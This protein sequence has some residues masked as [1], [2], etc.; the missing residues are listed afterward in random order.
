MLLDLEEGKD[1]FSTIWAPFDVA[2]IEANFPAEPEEQL[3]P[4]LGEKMA[5]HQFGYRVIHFYGQY[6]S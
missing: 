1:F 2:L 5:R 3:Q 6:C 4:A